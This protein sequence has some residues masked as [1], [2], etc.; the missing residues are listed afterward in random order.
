MSNKGVVRPLA[1]QVQVKYIARR[2]AEQSRALR[3][4]TF[5]P[6]K[7]LPPRPKKAATHD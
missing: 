5:P 7:Q 4:G 3:N 2:A 6:P 1:R